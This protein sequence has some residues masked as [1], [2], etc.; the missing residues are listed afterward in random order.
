VQDW[1]DLHELTSKEV[2]EYCDQIQSTYQP[3]IIKAQASNASGGLT[4]NF[5]K[6]LECLVLPSLKELLSGQDFDLSSVKIVRCKAGELDLPY[7]KWCDEISAPEI[8]LVWSGS[9]NDLV[10]LAHEMAHAAQMILSKNKFMPPVAREVCAF[11]GELALIRF[12]KAQSDALH[13]ELC[14]V[15]N[16]QNR[17]YLGSD[18]AQLGDDLKTEFAPYKYSHNYP[19]AR[20]AAMSMFLRQYK[21][22]PGGLFLSASTAM[23]WL[24][25]F[26]IFKALENGHQTGSSEQAARQLS[27]SPDAL[28]V[29]QSVTIDYSWFCEIPGANSILTDREIGAV[30]RV[31][32]QTWLK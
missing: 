8:H 6:S 27:L 4:L 12:A 22:P 1:L 2:L 16:R 23:E 24:G 26:D 32:P 5:D 28:I 15:W 3:D 14:G 25:F 30:D 20:L 10:C 13:K 17:R 18:I 9:A 21:N 11:L 31:P 7:T 29:A 19:L